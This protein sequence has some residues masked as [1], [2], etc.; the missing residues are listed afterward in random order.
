MKPLEENIVNLHDLK[1][2]KPFVDM[3][4]KAWAMKEKIS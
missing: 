4:P 3:T 1:L 2:H